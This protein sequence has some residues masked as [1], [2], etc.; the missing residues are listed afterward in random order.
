MALVAVDAG[1]D[2]IGFVLSDS[3]RRIAAEQA[4]EIAAVLPALVARVAVFRRTDEPGLAEALTVFDPDWV[5]AEGDGAALPEP[6]RRRHLPVLR[7]WAP[8]RATSPFFLMEGRKSG[9]GV[10]ADW[11]Q[12]AAAAR[13]GRMIL[14]GGLD[15]ANVGEA[16]RQVRPWGVDV[17]SGVESARGVKDE[18]LIREFLAA[19]RR[20]EQ[21][22]ERNEL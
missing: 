22:D 2:A 17:S 16:I 7:A 5:Q 8:G 21:R 3:P 18:A 15:P 4:A 9:E 12:A 13:Q 10:R 14:A 19:V 11:G 20:E 6:F 1:A